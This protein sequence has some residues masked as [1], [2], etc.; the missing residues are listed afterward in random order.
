MR[1]SA[2]VT[3]LG[4]FND[5]AAESTG[6]GEIRSLFDGHGDKTVIKFLEALLEKKPD[7]AQ[8]NSPAIRLLR[9]TL[10]K[11][12]ICLRNAAANKAA[13]DIAKL[14]EL[15][16]GCG[17]A[18]IDEFVRDARRWTVDYLSLLKQLSRDSV[19]FARTIERL[20]ADKEVKKP[21]VFEIA[22]GFL[23][24]NLDNQIKTR[25]AALNEIAK[26]QR[27]DA[28]T[29]ARETNIDQSNKPWQA[30]R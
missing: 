3:L 19:K 28:R 10:S 25:D 4:N 6:L 2:L 1:A 18:S 27:L 24:R 11:V 5:M 26:W 7:G 12:E 30:R 14:D 21:A 23:G 20:R 29:D 15:L 8:V 13:D 16:D 9:E 22:Q 17:Q